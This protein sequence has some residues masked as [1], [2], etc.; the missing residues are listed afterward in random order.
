MSDAQD[1]LEIYGHDGAL[2]RTIAITRDSD[3]PTKWHP[4]S[5]LRSV[6]STPRTR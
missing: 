5:P 4:R 6:A 1:V 3:D 2:I